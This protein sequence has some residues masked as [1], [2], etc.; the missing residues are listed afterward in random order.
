[1]FKILFKRNY[2]PTAETLLTVR[3][4]GV[5]GPMKLQEFA[6][7]IFVDNI[8]DYTK[9]IEHHAPLTKRPSYDS[10]SL[11]PPAVVSSIMISSFFFTLL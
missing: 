2:K 6:R 11:E 10:I 3:A 5:C 7:I 9:K 1:M 4:L 8:F